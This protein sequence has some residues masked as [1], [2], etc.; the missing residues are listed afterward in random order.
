MKA[1]YI[2]K[3]SEKL[4][5]SG[6]SPEDD[7]KQ[8]HKLQNNLKL[9]KEKNSSR[10]NFIKNDNGKILNVDYIPKELFSSYMNK[11]QNYESNNFK[12]SFLNEKSN[13]IKYF[14]QNDSYN[15][16]KIYKNELNNISESY[17]KSEKIFNPN[18][19]NNKIENSNSNL[20]LNGNISKD[21]NEN[22]RYKE[23][24]INQSNS[25]NKNNNLKSNS[26]N[27]NKDIISNESSTLRQNLSNYNGLSDNFINSNL[28]F[29]NTISNN[30]NILS[31]QNNYLDKI[32]LKELEN[33]EKFL[34]ELEAKRNKHISDLIE[35]HKIE[36]SK[37]EKELENMKKSIHENYFIE[38]ESKNISY[39]KEN[40]ANTNNNIE[41]NTDEINIKSIN[42]GNNLNK[43]NEIITYFNQLKQD[44][45]KYQRNS[46]YSTNNNYK[47]TYSF[48][49]KRNKLM[50]PFNSPTLTENKINNKINHLNYTSTNFKKNAKKK[51]KSTKK[52][53]SSQK[54]SINIMKSLK[55]IDYNPFN[56]LKI[57]NLFKTCNNGNK[58]R[59]IKKRNYSNSKGK[60]K[61]QEK[62]NTYFNCFFPELYEEQKQKLIKDK[63]IKKSKS[64]TKIKRLEDYIGPNLYNEEVET[65]DFGYICYKTNKKINPKYSLNYNCLYNSRNNNFGALD[66]INALNEEHYSSNIDLRTIYKNYENFKN[67]YENE[68]ENYY[69]QNQNYPYSGYYNEELI[70]ENTYYDL[71]NKAFNHFNYPSDKYNYQPNFYTNDIKWKLS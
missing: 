17:N 58:K 44:S 25:K 42:D 62:Y 66:N 16:F 6:N 61:I 18:K 52:F 22:Q 26:N 20:H 54:S 2:N 60:E 33:K 59:S 29:S 41:Y 69:V 9:L 51:S 13:E 48:N 46:N 50:S 45:I 23:E 3:K 27:I 53:D 65:P 8:K 47:T 7:N 57:M 4:K 31:S 68:K 30:S 39:Q 5:N 35:K 10:N 40:K 15:N 1:N 36:F 55:S 38:K 12:S 71:Y 63:K 11:N 19:N 28:F 43:N 14:T 67:N 32:K 56:S 24:E 21:T 49:I 70:D 37:K 64:T 34:I